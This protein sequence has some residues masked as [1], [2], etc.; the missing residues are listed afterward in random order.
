MSN[1]WVYARAPTP[2]EDHARR[3]LHQ[4]SR[5]TKPAGS[6]GRLE[7]LAVELA[8]LQRT[9]H[10]QATRAPILIFAGDHGVA[11]QGVSAYPAAV[12]VEMLRNFANGGAAISVLARELGVPLTVID[13]GTLSQHPIPGVVTDKPRCGTR[14][15]SI[16]A[17][18]LPDEVTFALRCG[19]EA[20]SRAIALGADILILGEMG[21]GNTTS[22]AAVASALTGLSPEHLVGHG[23][24]VDAAGLERKIDLIGRAL[25]LQGLA[26]GLFPPHGEPVGDAELHP[27]RV[28]VFEILEKVGGLEIVALVGALIA[29]AQAGVP[30]LVDGFIVSV[31]ALAAVR[32]N[33]SCRPWLMFSHTSAERGHILVLDALKAQPILDLDMRLGEGSGAAVALPVLRLACALHNGMATFEAAAVSGRIEK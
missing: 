8:A 21:I 7:G 3:A 5:L 16:E 2:S 10:P 27:P 14:D 15:F 25:A 30:V 19:G 29:S 24:G 13:A 18:L 17:A 4:Q 6:L 9:E 11:A 33:P 20:V 22:A 23:T 26:S 32:L 31:A 12:T 1:D 28:C